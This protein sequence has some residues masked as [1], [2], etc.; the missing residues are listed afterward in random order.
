MAVAVLIGVTTVL[1]WNNAATTFN[2]VPT[3][4][5]VIIPKGAGENLH[6]GFEPA[7]IMI[8]IG[9]N[10]TI[11]WKNEDSDWHTA[12]SNIPEFNSG[13]IAPGGNF[14]HIFLRAGVYPYHCDPHPWMTGVVTVKASTG[15]GMIAY[16]PHAQSLSLETNSL[17]TK[18]IKS[19]V[20]CTSPLIDR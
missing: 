7:K 20:F 9:I 14:T 6:L 5:F 11:V 16:W 3:V 18:P 12:H 4:V 8:V 2:T 13:L 1:Y 19:D 10:N 15:T 17:T